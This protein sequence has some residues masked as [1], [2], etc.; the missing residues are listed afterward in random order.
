MVYF[1]KCFFRL[2][3]NIQELHREFEEFLNEI[4]DMYNNDLTSQQIKHLNMAKYPV[5]NTFRKYN[6]LIKLYYDGK[7]TKRDIIGEMEY[8]EVFLD[9]MKNILRL[10]KFKITK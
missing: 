8:Y 4:D 5:I 6:E 3:K 1:I 10:E 9:S 7:I 2:D